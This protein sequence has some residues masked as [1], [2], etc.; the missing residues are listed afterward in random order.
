MQ[1]AARD[2]ILIGGGEIGRCLTR[3]HHDRFTPIERVPDPV[4]ADRIDRGRR[5]EETVIAHLLEDTPPTTVRFPDAV[6]DPGRPVVIPPGVKPP[7]R[8][9]ITARALSARAPLVVGG[10]LSSASLRS[11]GAPDLL[12]R[13]ELGYAPVDVKHH[14]VARDEGI[15]ARVTPVRAITNVVGAEA[16]FKPD[17]SQDLLQVAH[18]WRLLDEAG[19]ADQRRFAGIIGSEPGPLCIWVDLGV[20]DPTLLDVAAAELDEA[21]QVVEAG[22]EHPETPLVP[23][24]WRGVCRSCPWRDFCRGELEAVDHV[25]LL[26]TVRPADTERLTAAGI[27]TT[28]QLATTPPGT[29]IDD[30]EMNPESILEAKAR[31]RGALLRR[32][33]IDL[34]LPSADVTVDFDI[35]TY[36]GIVYLAGLL[37]TD[38]GKSTYR[39][40]A[41]WTATDSGE[42]EVITDLF[43][44]FD[45]LAGRG[46]AVVFHWTG[47]ERTMLQAASDRHGVRLRTAPDVDAWFDRYGCDLW[48]WTKARFVSPDGYSL[49]VVAPLCGFAWR[50]D[51]PGGAQSELWY[52][53]AVAGDAA[54]R[55]R[56]LDYNEDDVAAQLAIRRW[57]RDPT[58]RQ[59]G[60]A[61]TG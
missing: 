35:E 56:L 21:V 3:I 23:A 4:V 13:L 41:D 36:R 45:R 5:W 50:D 42:Q 28:R 38:A 24:V 60:A 48:A 44:F 8:E 37:I 22:S 27:T 16:F 40:I 51:D 59:L 61:T 7:N 10:R 2:P 1:R 32:D 58:D 20:A 55:Q 49:K 57:V 53:D 34:D 33:G 52:V 29:A 46:N 6:I 26:P 31:G 11:V 30:Y 9:E 14:L 43:A 19:H 25:S 12:V 18:Y 39:P 47:Y 54:Q 17:R 15:P